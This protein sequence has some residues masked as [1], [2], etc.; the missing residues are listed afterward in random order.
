VLKVAHHGSHT[1][2]SGEFLD[3]AAPAIAL[4][5]C[6]KNNLYGHPHEEVLKRL[7]RAGTQVFR[8]DE[9]GAVR[10]ISDGRCFESGT[11]VP[12]VGMKAKLW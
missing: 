6:G 3:L 5:S 10:V 9:D 8:S 7:G 1:S 2:T 12:S 4:I 11:F